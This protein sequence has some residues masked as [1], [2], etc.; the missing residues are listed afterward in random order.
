MI[1]HYLKNNLNDITDMQMYYLTNVLPTDEIEY[2]ET[3]YLVNDYMGLHKQGDFN[4]LTSTINFNAMYDFN[5]EDLVSDGFTINEFYIGSGSVIGK[6]NVNITA[7]GFTKNNGNFP[8]G[9]NVTIDPTFSTSD[10]ESLSAAPMDVDKFIVAWCDES[11]NNVEAKIYWTN[12]TQWG[13]QITV[14]AVGGCDLD[15]GVVSVTA[16]NT[17][18][19]VVAYF[20]DGVDDAFFSTYINHTSIVSAQQVDDNI[21]TA[22]RVDIDGIDGSDF[23]YGYYDDD[24]VSIFYAKYNFEGTELTAPTLFGGQNDESGA[25]SIAIATLNSTH[26]VIAWD[27]ADANEMKFGILGI[28][29]EVVVESML[30]SLSV[31]LATF[32]STHFVLSYFQQGNDD[33]VYATYDLITP[34]SGIQTTDSTGPAAATTA[35]EDVAIINSTHFVQIWHDDASNDG[36]SS[37]QHVEGNVVAGNTFISNPTKVIPSVAVISEEYPVDI[38]ICGDNLIAISVQASNVAEYGKFYSN[39]TAWSGVCP[40]QPDFGTP[41]INETTIFPGMSINHTVSMLITHHYIC[42]LGMLQ[43]LDV[44][45]GKILHG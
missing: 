4:D 2:N 6:S 38:G 39:G 43:G 20:D 23:W 3:S 7:I 40:D 34:I 45:H 8:K 16:L 14:D 19:W 26:F 17:S 24:A 28:S 11:S 37:V 30:N 31:S 5:F 29:D 12:D 1:K 9:M 13:G 15:D 27:D 44:I 10:V 22:G 25:D 35:S 32:N 18:A 33:M 36:K 42:S 21:G 41:T